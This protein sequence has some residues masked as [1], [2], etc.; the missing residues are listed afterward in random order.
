MTAAG[1]G[2]GYL[3]VAHVGAAAE[4]AHRKRAE[5]LATRDGAE[6]VLVMPGGAEELDTSLEQAELHAELDGER[7]VVIG[8]GLEHGEER[9]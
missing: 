7:Q 3:E 5:D 4:F 2:I 9:A 6:E 8:E 1:V